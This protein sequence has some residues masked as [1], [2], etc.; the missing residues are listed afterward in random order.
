VLVAVLTTVADLATTPPP[1]PVAA[2]AL[3]GEAIKLTA[4]GVT[5]TAVDVDFRSSS[6]GVAVDDTDCCAACHRI[7]SVRARA[8]TKS[9]YLC[10]LFK[11]TISLRCLLLV[12]IQVGPA[13]DFAPIFAEFQHALCA[14]HAMRPVTRKR[15]TPRCS[16][17]INLA[18][19]SLVNMRR[20]DLFG[21]GVS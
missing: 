6:L 5:A 2:L 19:S 12:A 7:K 16:T 1:P 13:N 14:C 11:S 20:C 17:S 21:G 8:S 15:R 4:T 10:V 9:R 18:S 3:L